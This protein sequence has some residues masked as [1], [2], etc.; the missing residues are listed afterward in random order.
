MHSRVPAIIGINAVL[1][2]ALVALAVRLRS[3]T[4][5]AARRDPTTSGEG[6]GLGARG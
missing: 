1:V 6:E 5:H 4:P 3:R 2:A